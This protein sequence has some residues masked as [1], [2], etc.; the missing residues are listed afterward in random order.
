MFA[1][2][3]AFL[4]TLGILLG[5]IKEALPTPSDKIESDKKKLDE[6]DEETKKTGRPKW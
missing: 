3:L 2:I 1:Q 6:V 4:K 5:L